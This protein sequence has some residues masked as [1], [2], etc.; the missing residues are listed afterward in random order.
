VLSV[1]FITL[2]KNITMNCLDKFESD[3]ILYHYTKTTT[4][5]EHILYNKKLRLSDRGNS[6]DPIENMNPSL[7]ISFGVINLSELKGI[8][9]EKARDD[10]QRVVNDIEERMK[11]LKQVCFCMNDNKNYKEN[12]IKPL[13]YFG[14]M[15]PRMWE[16]YA[17]NYNGVCL[18]LSKNKLLKPLDDDNYKRRNINYTNYEELKK[19]DLEIGFQEMFNLGYE[20]SKQ[21]LFDKMG[22]DIFKKPKDYEGENEY[23]ICSYSDKGILDINIESALKG[24]VVSGYNSQFF[25]EALRKYGEKHGI[26]IL[27]IDWKNSGVDVYNMND[28]LGVKQKN[29]TIT[30]GLIKR[31]I[32]QSEK[33]K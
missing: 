33:F 9:I 4:A 2:K 19:I 7:W 32:I 16:Q 5:L 29:K 30:E 18:I 10:M 12:D 21:M 31:E 3:D 27:Q 24:I 17:D 14:C 13:E 26:E 23:R 6:R 1:F 22:E 8:Q 15:K 20:N 11:Q 28:M 25:K